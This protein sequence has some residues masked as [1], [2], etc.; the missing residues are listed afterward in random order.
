[1]KPIIKLSIVAT[2]I[3]CGQAIFAQDDFD[4]QMRQTINKHLNNNNCEKAKTA[5]DAWGKTDAELARRVA[6]CG[7]TTTSTTTAKPVVAATSTTD[8]GVVINGVTWA[9]RNVGEKGKFVAQPHYAGNSYTLKEAKTVCPAGWRLPNK[10]EIVLLKDFANPWTTKNGINGR[11]F[12]TIPNT[13][14]L[15]VT[16]GTNSTLDGSYSDAGGYWVCEIGC[17]Y[18]GTNMYCT[19]YCLSFSSHEVSIKGEASNTNF[20]VRCVKNNSN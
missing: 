17:I 8:P 19:G 9:T 4:A 3:L 10:D 2:L 18:T 16:A 14:F 11:E 13:I 12:G 6:N 7:K 5:Y 15:P 1:M 20:S